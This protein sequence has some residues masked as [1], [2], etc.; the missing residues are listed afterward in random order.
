MRFD[1][2]RSF[3]EA[4]RKENELQVIS[5]PVDP[6]LELAEIHRRVIDE[7]GPA[8]LFTNVKGAYFPVVTNLFGT[9]RRVDLAFGPRPEQLMKQIVGAV[10]TLVPPTPKAL[11]QQR[12]LIVDLLKIGIKNVSPDSAP[13]LQQCK[14]DSPLDGLPVLTSWQEDGGPFVTLPLVYTE[15]PENGH[16]NLGMYRMQVYDAKTTGMHW[17]IHKGGGFHYHEAEKR[18]E[19]L[20]VTVFLGGPP[21]L[22]ASAIAPVPEHLPELLLTSLIVGQKLPMVQNPHGGH[23]LVAE[24]E[25]A[26]SGSVAPYLR[27]PEGPFGDHYGYYSLTHDFPV[28]EVSHMWHRKDAIYPATIVGKPR[29]EDYYLGE[30]LQRLLSPAF[31]MAMPGVKDL[32]TYAETGFHP[33]AAAIV[34]DSYSREALGTAFRILGEGQL[35]L[36]K[37][38]IVTDQHVELERFPKLLETVLERF[39]PLRDLFIFDHTSHDTLDYTGDRLNHGSKAVLLGVGEPQRQLPAVYD[40]GELP[41]IRSLAVYCRGCLVVSGAAYE[42]DPLLPQHLVEQAGDRLGDWPLVILA[43]DTSFVKDQ[44]AFLW[45]V[46]TRFNPAGDIYAH[47]QVNR[48]HIGYRLP[49][50]IDARMKPGYPD[51][52]FPREDIVELVDR[53]WK[54]YFS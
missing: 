36:T 2:L 34:R 7:G 53:R 11:W 30:F 49:L 19:A 12:Q 54:E 17:Q 33:L 13:I 6:Y 40:G 45:T 39:D 38:L 29:Q 9:S 52:L 4:L 28:F 15:H 37:F 27:R 8:L 23:R 31:P 10:D 50:V 32:W 46:F 14:T 21:A 47:T 42:E 18:G 5:A 44:T 35:T 51:E 48:H 24:A 22:I 3:L 16:H 25:F 43:D 1:N 26:I 20:P 41:G